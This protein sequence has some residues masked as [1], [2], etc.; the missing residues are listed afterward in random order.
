MGRNGEKDGGVFS[1]ESGKEGEGKKGSLRTRIPLHSSQRTATPHDGDRA[2]YGGMKKE[3]VP[4]Q[5]WKGHGQ[6]KTVG[7]Q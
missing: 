1:V 6:K 3:V 5:E 4:G 7:E 2:S